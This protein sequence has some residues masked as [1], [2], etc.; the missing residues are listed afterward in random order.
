MNIHDRI[1][2]GKSK[3]HAHEYILTKQI[4][5]ALNQ[6][7][8]LVG[9]KGHRGRPAYTPTLDQNLFEPLTPENRACF[10]RGD[11]GELIGSQYSPAKMQ[12]VHSSAALGVNLF[13]YWQKIGQIPII[14]AECG[15]C[16]KGNEISKAIVFEEKYPIDEDRFRFAPNIDILIHNSDLF[17]IKRFAIE[18]KFSEAYDSR[19][20]TGLKPE[21]LGM[22]EIW[23]DIPHLHRL[24][25][26]LSPD[27]H[28]FRFLHAAQLVKHILGLKRALGK[29]GFRLLYLWYDVL[30]EAGVIHRKEAEVFRE[31]AKADEIKFHSVSYQELIAQLSKS[32]RTLHAEY[33]E[34]IS[35]RYL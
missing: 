20:H 16:R 7:I 26:T 12:A 3:M 5:W 31:A 33:I 29:E 30:G 35:D 22:E 8:Q 9:S 6:G 23:L 25:K 1:N 19:G 32:Y 15:L 28:S 13:Q 17:K 27:D 10:E 24:S 18:C 11:G 21:Y 34:Y 14:A 2:P 4:Q